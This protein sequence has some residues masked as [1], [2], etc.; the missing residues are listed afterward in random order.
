M[1]IEGYINTLS[2]FIAGNMSD[3]K[4]EK[5]VDDRLSELRRSPEMNP[6]R[7]ILSTIDLYLH[8]MNECSRDEAELYGFIRAVLDET[9]QSKDVSRGITVHER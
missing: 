7:R 6:E 5:A 4:S 9:T 8:E 3:S 2:L 1:A